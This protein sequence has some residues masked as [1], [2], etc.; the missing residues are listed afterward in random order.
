MS[1]TTRMPHVKG[2]DNGGT[3]D[4]LALDKDA[5]VQYVGQARQ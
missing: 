5:L 3:N 2:G 1:L 4:V